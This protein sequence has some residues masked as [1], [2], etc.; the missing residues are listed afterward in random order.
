MPGRRLGVSLAFAFIILL[1]LGLSGCSR[2]LVQNGMNTG[3]GE[4]SAPASS[5]QGPGEPETTLT[6]YFGGDKKALTDKVWSKVSDYVKAK[7]LNVDFSIRFIPWPDYSGKLLVMAASGDKWDLNFDSENSFQQMAARGS[8]MPL[9][10]LLPKDAPHLYERYKNAGTTLTAAT[11]NGEIVG[12]P[13]TVKM[14]QRFYAG[15][16]ADLAEKAG[17]YRS[18][19][20]VRTIEDVDEL[21]HELKM[22]Y[23]DAK[24]TRTNSLPIYQTRDEWA[25]LGFHGLGFY[26]NDPRITVRAIEEQPFYLEAAK[27]SKRWYDDNILNRDAMIDK[28]STAVQWRN[29]KTLFTLTSHEWAY[30]ADPGFA[31]PS[32]RQQMSLL[33][34]DRKFVNRSPIANVLAINRNSEHAD[35]VLRFL[36]MVETDRTL[37]DLV[38]YGIEG[39]TYQLDGDTAA[40]PDH[41]EFASSNYMDWEG[42]WAFWNPDFMRPTQTYP[43]G[44]W[45]E[46]TRFA[47]LPMNVESPVEGL[48]ITDGNVSSELE[49]RDQVYEDMGKAIEYGDVDNVEQSL[50]AYIQKQKSSGLQ[51]IIDDVQSQ[52]DRYLASRPR[53]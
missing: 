5:A 36:D 9:N 47:E 52:V 31:D 34:P 41:M 28:E 1:Q 25:D 3:L 16:R 17:I 38:I 45:K 15:W 7:G 46:E 20:S 48:F 53:G 44:F 6:F 26:L 42:Q 23:P 2:I 37:Y 22:A 40:Y 43:E 51:N 33:Y 27:M 30:A 29:G 10:D 49:T 21:L 39:E 35:L 4:G 8:Y 19:D 50:D 13:W 24:L 18:P 14:N 32:Y 12:L 11:V